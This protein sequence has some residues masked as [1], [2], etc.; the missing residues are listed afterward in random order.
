MKDLA[1]VK[2]GG[3]Y[4]LS[5]RLDAAIAALQ[6]AR[7][8]LVVVPGGG[9]FA[10][11]VRRAQPRMRFDDAAADRMALLAMA[12]FGEA[13]CSLA[14]RFVMA[15]SVATIRATLAKGGIPVW[16]PLAMA[17]RSGL[18]RNWDV[19]SDSLSLWLADRLGARDVV[20]VK[21]VG[22]PAGAAPEE[23]A[24]AGIIDRTAPRLLAAADLRLRLIG[25][26]DL[27][28]LAELVAAEAPHRPAAAACR[29]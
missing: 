5:P 9:P 11:A 29:P 6:A 7:R 27:A 2:L 16:S 8:P 1:V 18:P 10:D 17:A 12:Q 4:A 24:A 23:L 15:A 22:A 26:E 21:S 28:R 13:L 19:T 14:P 25:P 3:S 20:L